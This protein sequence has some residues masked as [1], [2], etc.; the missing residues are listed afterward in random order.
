VARATVNRTNPASGSAHVVFTDASGANREGVVV[1]LDADDTPVGGSTIGSG[2]ALNVAGVAYPTTS[3][4]ITTATTTVT[5]G[6]IGVAGNITI[7][8][9]G[10]YAGVSVVFEASPDGGTTWVGIG[11]SREDTGGNEGATAFALP[12]NAARLWTTGAPGFTNFRVRA[13]AWTSGSASVIILPGTYPFE[14]MV[15]AIQTPLVSTP[16]RANVASSASSVT[17]RAANAARKGLVISNA[18]AATL[19][20]D[21]TGGTATTTTA[22]SFPLS[23]GQTYV[24]DPTTFTTGLVT[25]IWAATGGSGANVTEFT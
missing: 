2:R 6:N 3:G 11:A 13:T 18:G 14:P 21:L 20:V 23:P 24:M 19:Y 22:N 9:F 7:A 10:T 17:L 15:T 8:I 1:A 12:T 4:A 5:T 25:G 16:T